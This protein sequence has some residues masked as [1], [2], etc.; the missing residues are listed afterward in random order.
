MAKQ[1]LVLIGGGVRSGKS[2]FALSRARRFG[3]RLVFVATAEPLD[4]EMRER[5]QRH[6]A[7]RGEAFRTVE[8]PRALVACLRELDSARSADGVVIDCLTLW[9]SNL[10]VDGL[11]SQEIDGRVVELAEC[12]RAASFASVIVSNE[13]GLGIVPDNAMARA[14]RD[15]TGRAHQTLAHVASELYFGVM[16]QLLRL[17]PAPVELVGAGF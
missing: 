13:V 14:F 1:E 4:D 6:Q 7:E 3:E 5:A 2:A 10:M 9:I 15:I 17:K 8:C 16:G 11:A 12:L